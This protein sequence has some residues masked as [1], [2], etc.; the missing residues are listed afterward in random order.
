[1]PNVYA[2]RVQETSTTTGTGTYDLAGATTSYQ[3]F[4]AGAGDGVSVTYVADD[5]TDW[6]VGTGTVTDAAPDTLS[7]DTIIDSSNAGSAVNWGAGTRTISLTW[8]AFDISG[9]H[10]GKD[11]YLTTTQPVGVSAAPFILYQFDGS[12]S[13]LTDRSANTNDLTL[14]S[15]SEIYSHD[16]IRGGIKLSGSQALTAAGDASY[17]ITGALTLELLISL[18]D[19]NALQTAIICFAS[20]ETEATNSLYHLQFQTTMACDVMWEFGAGSNVVVSGEDNVFSPHNKTLL[21]VTR[22]SDGSTCKSYLNGALVQTDTGLTAPTGGTS[23]ALA[24]GAINSS[25]EQC[26]GIFYCVRGT[27]EEFTAAQVLASYEGLKK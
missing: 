22:S 21:T 8:T 10:L 27:G 17:R 7:R 25:T 13:S 26:K 16:G 11:S 12:A 24:V 19:A 2:E 6:E 4:V 18:Y 15:G 20:G 3:G 5:G 14:S 1:M 23:G 9:L